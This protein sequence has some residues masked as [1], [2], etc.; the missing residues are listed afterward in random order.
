M[1]QAIYTQ[2]NECR[3][4]YKCVRHCPVKAIRVVDSRASIDHSLCI[5]CGNCTRICP[6]GVKKIRN[7]VESVKTLLKE[8]KTI[9]S[10]APSAESEFGIPME[11]LAGKLLKLGFFKVS[12]TAL[13]AEMV[14]REAI[15]LM[16]KTDSP[17]IST[18][19]PAVVQLVVKYYPKLKNL[20]S[21]IPSPMAAHAE[22]L[23]A[24]FEGDVAVV[25]IGPCAAKKTEAEQNPLLLDGAIT[26][27]ELKE[28]LD[29]ADTLGAEPADFFPRR[30]GRATLFPLEGGMAATMGIPNSPDKKGALAL[31]GLSNCM[32]LLDELNE[33]EYEP[34]FIELLACEGGCINGPGMSV[35]GEILKKRIP[36]LKRAQISKSMLACD[37]K[38]P[39]M[40]F[41]MECVVNCPENSEFSEEEIE[42]ALSET[43]KSEESERLN[44]GGCGY[45]SCRNFAVAYLRGKAEKEMCVTHM[46]KLAQKTSNALMQSVPMAAAIL[47][48]D[49]KIIECNPKFITTF[50]AFDEA[51]EK[52]L[53]H[54]VGRSIDN[55]LPLSD[56]L[57]NM[58][59]E[60]LVTS[61]P[62]AENRIFKGFFFSI[63]RGS[64][65]GVLLQD[66]TEPTVYR[67]EV[68]R[69]AE[70]LMSKNLA[71]VQQIASLLG[72]NAADTQL[73]LNSLIDAFKPSS[74]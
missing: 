27:K 13:G 29:E 52:E 38:V 35:Q 39:E 42:R 10:L 62:D 40:K 64:M 46:R 73:I 71:S 41:L 12:E 43:G 59:E 30:A 49:Y 31:S 48:S 74:E 68:I 6:A 70:E 4:C 8:K 53:A 61:I 15:G 21:P 26:F 51:T 66:I 2:Q 17:V 1:T 24:S 55:F 37:L 36:V 33:N 7:D 18:A 25:F 22:F 50:T 57:M 44:C 16:E 23:K 3:D 14:S 5:F 67:E 9:V 54:A 45:D 19:C 69:K 60:Q 58:K 65:T 28:W 20:L 47:D 34:I 32:S 72:E 56:F 11:E 63:Q